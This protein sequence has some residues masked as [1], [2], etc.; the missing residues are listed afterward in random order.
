MEDRQD[1]CAAI[2]DDFRSD[3]VADHEALGVVDPTDETASTLQ[4]RGTRVTFKGP[5]E[6][7]LADLI[8]GNRVP[9]RAGLRF[10]RVSGQKRVYSARFEG[11]VS[12]AFEDWIE[13]NLLEVER[14]QVQQITLNEYFIDERT[15]SVVR[16]GEFILDKTAE[17]DWNA[18]SVPA[19]QE[20]DWAQHGR[21]TT[22]GSDVLRTAAPTVCRRPA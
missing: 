2:K 14:N 16:R 19:G 12:T 18:D 21:S 4:G 1:Q 17:G 8:I 3:N 20:R 15:L 22:A 7:V 9:G 6:E 10:V 13:T 5:N 11:N